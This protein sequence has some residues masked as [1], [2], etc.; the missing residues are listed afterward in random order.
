MLTDAHRRA[1]ARLNPI[2]QAVMGKE[3]SG[4]FGVEF[5]QSG[6]I[7]YVKVSFKDAPTLVITPDTRDGRLDV[8]L[9]A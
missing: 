9:K 3:V 7:K 2:R 8:G 1:L 6:R 5:D 4:H